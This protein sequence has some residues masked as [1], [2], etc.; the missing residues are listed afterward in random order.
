MRHQRES[1]TILN[2]LN[3][4]LV[5]DV[6]N[7]NSVNDVLNV[8]TYYLN[9]SLILQYNLESTLFANSRVS[10]FLASLYRMS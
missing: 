7:A 5:N 9:I 8:V 4:L 2:S 10:F 1:G 3:L 6:L